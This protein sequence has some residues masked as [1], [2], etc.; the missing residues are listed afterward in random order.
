MTIL[1][2]GG[3]V[4]HSDPNAIIFTDGVRKVILTCF[5][6][7]IRIKGPGGDRHDYTLGKLIE[8]TNNQG[9]YFPKINT[10]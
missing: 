10:V 3:V 5:W 8:N 6:W 1:R 4:T 9:S 7:P 2:G